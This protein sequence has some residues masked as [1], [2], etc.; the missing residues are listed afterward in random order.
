VR[1]LTHA[2]QVPAIKM[3]LAPQT[4]ERLSAPATLD[5]QAM[6]RTATER[7]F[8]TP[9]TQTAPQPPTAKRNQMA[10]LASANLLLKGTATNARLWTSA[11]RTVEREGIAPQRR[12]ARHSVSAL[13]DMH[14]MENPSAKEKH[15][16]DHALMSMNARFQTSAQRM[17]S[18]ST[19]Q[20][21]I[22]V[23]ATRVTKEMAKSVLMRMNAWKGSVVQEQPV[24]TLRDHAFVPVLK[25]LGQEM[26]LALPVKM[27]MNA[28]RETTTART[29]RTAST[30]SQGTI[31]SA[32]MATQEPL[33][34]TAKT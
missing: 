3:P 9:L 10:S 24:S 30:R 33:D 20:E 18:A 32:K 6:E 29:Q 17:Q 11:P 8:A 13:R 27:L 5:S 1:R 16:A 26:D 25:G 15:V 4:K 14:L 2:T 12:M 19:N 23:N 28:K 7:H 21:D 31:A 34:M 22:L